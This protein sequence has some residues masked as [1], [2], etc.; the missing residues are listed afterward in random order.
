MMGKVEYRETRVIV[1][2]ISIGRIYVFTL[3]PSQFAFLKRH[4][5]YQ[6]LVV[7]EPNCHKNSRRHLQ[8]IRQTFAV[9]DLNIIQNQVLMISTIMVARRRVE[10]F[11]IAENTNQW[12]TN[13]VL[14]PLMT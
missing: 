3:H 14:E 4:R 10:L 7:A 12:A 9:L 8:S 6:S 5:I 13:G 11:N 1:S 2:R